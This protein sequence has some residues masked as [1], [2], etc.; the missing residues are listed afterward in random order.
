VTPNV[1]VVLALT[2]IAGFVDAAAFFHS[3]V[4][5]AN[6]TGNTVL[7]GG[8]VIGLFVPKM[9]GNIGI[10]LPAIALGCFLAGAIITGFASRGNRS[11]F[12]SRRL[13]TLLGAMAALLAVAAALQ[14]PGSYPLMLTSI[15]VLS[16][17]MG[18]QS[19]VAMRLGV[20][21]VTTVVVTSTLTRAVLD[22]I[23]G[24]GGNAENPRAG[25]LDV[26]VWAL[27]LGGAL[28]GTG[29]LLLLGPNAFWV[30]AVVVAAL[31]V[32]I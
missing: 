1:R 31:A 13:K 19:V 16:V 9:K 20:S 25:R 22:L 12:P 6:M 11:A 30:A 18:A 2:A 23:D 21:G 28:A 7:L 32:V 4:F 14:L 24:S 26:T 27:Y 10:I 5:T 3:G 29:A 8:A 15:A 17:V